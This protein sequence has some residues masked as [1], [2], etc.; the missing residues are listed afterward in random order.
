MKGF[1]R[2]NFLICFS[3]G[4]L[5]T[6]NARAQSET[7]D[8]N[9]PSAQ[10]IPLIEREFFFASPEFIDPKLS[11][12]GQMISFFRL[13]KGVKNIWVKKTDD[14]FSKSY[15]I[16]ASEEPLNNAHWTSDSKL[17]LFSHNT[18]DNDVYNVFAVDPLDSSISSL[19]VP[20][21]RNLTPSD[22]QSI[23]IIR[24][25]AQDSDLVWV[26]VKNKDLQSDDLCKFRIST[27]SLTAVR[28]N[29][30]HISQF[31]FDWNEV[32]R[33]GTRYDAKDSSMELLRLNKDGSSTK[34]FDC[35]GLE[36]CEVIGFSGDNQWVFIK[37]NKGEQQDLIRLIRLNPESLKWNDVEQDPLNKVDLD[38]VHLGDSTHEL[39]FTTYVDD[40]SRVYWKD[41][42]YQQDE[43]FLRSKFPDR[44]IAFGHSS[45]NEQ[46]Y[47]IDLYAD[48]KLPQVYTFD[49]DT[50]SL[51]PQYT[52]YSRLKPSENALSKMQPETYQSSDGTN[53]GAYLSMP[54]GYPS[55]NLP[56][57]VM[58]HDGPW[59]RNYWGFNHIVQWLNS[60]GY[61]VLQMNY[62][63]SAG[64]GK[65]FLNAG[66]KQWGLLMQDDITWGI[67]DLISRGIADPRRIAIMGN[68][69]GGYA[70]LA[71][72]AF[73][74]DIYAAAVA[75]NGPANLNSMISS[76]PPTWGRSRKML[77]ERVG[78][79][80]RQDVR[81][82]LERTSPINADSAIRSPLLMVLDRD[83]S[84]IE[85]IETD[86]LVI[87]L[88]DSGRKVEYLDIS[89]EPQNANKS[90][91][92]S[93]V[94]AKAESFLGKNLHSRYQESIR[95][96]VAKK[97]QEMTVDVA[98]LTPGLAMA[99]S[100][101][102]KF[103][104]YSA[105]LS[106][107]SYTYGLMADLR[108]R[109]IPLNM[110]R[111]IVDDSLNWIVTDKIT[112]QM[113]E[114]TDE[115][116]YQKGSLIPVSRKTT[117]R[118]ATNE[119]DYFGDDIRANLSGKI[120]NSS[121]EGSYL[122]DGAGIDMLI[123]RMPLKEGFE[124]AF[125]LV[126]DD[127]KPKLYQLKVLGREKMNGANCFK[128][129]LT[130]VDNTTITTVMWIS[131]TQKMAYRIIVP[132]AALPGAKMTIDL[133]QQSS[134]AK[135][136][137]FLWMSTPAHQME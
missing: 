8:V 102:Q 93:A 20:Y 90:S 75:I 33:I 54:K 134:Q 55:R 10:P 19:G 89:D 107:G 44:Q 114:Q 28:K 59:K 5:L 115:A 101:V 105:D 81:M 38:R 12:D 36:Y 32:P 111:T 62:R 4:I 132:L 29:T 53:I 23:K 76:V 106:Q 116:V 14:P 56:L 87:S 118:N 40:K 124:S 16:T 88:R 50:K 6:A 110:T 104:P 136:I 112:G 57:I 49:R 121:V 17:I 74:A 18:M 7:K 31:S 43:L 30:D 51:T 60:R 77:M 71:G 99:F 42:S 66:N 128:V 85:R 35:S 86:Q 65:K 15:P 129:E 45:A 100:P 9:P 26:G 82:K 39:L 103:P 11:P 133:L 67:N 41:S 46:R 131:P 130:N 97:L 24:T 78:D 52:E 91:Y 61:A 63:G 123:A 73:T 125:N 3:V 122:H 98:A 126:G 113:G 109:R 117:Q 84:R 120:V 94:Y 58:P 34:I 22:S 96:D 137:L 64:F 127:G 92:Q 21:V 95:P 72:L 47:L 1:I 13:Y 108:N 70:S 135:F 69:Y 48:D 25:S 27:G 68:G 37:T 119:Y 83:K 2:E 79:N 80:S